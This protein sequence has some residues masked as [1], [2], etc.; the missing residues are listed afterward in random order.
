MK[1]PGI[2][3]LVIFLF[4]FTAFHHSEAKRKNYY[5]TFEILSITEKGLTLQDNDGNI[6]EVDKDPGDYKVGYKVRYDSVRNRLRGYRWQDYKVSAISSDKITLRHETGDTLSVGGNYVGKYDVG[7]Q[8]RYDS[9]GNKLQPDEDSGQWKQYTVV[10]ALSNKII[11][12]SN[13]GQQIILQM[14][15][16]LYPERRGVYIGK[17]KV[18]DLVRYNA[19]TNK[20]KKG[21]LRTYDWQDY[22]I[23]EV[24]EDQLILIN[25]NKKELILENTYRT[26]FNAGDLVKYD[27]LNNLLKKTRETKY[28]N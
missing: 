14:D 15:N 26:Q 7:D 10:E 8:V 3:I 16:N 1:K 18:G 6:I 24:T 23:K 27:R 25:K 13:Y 28:R 22:K 17:Y 4:I 21:V 20:L 5:R 19:T 12:Q 9:V 11:L 2:T